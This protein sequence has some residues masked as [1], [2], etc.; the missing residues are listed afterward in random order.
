MKMTRMV[1]ELTLQLVLHPT[2]TARL[3]LLIQPLQK[4]Q[5]LLQKLPKL[6]LCAMHCIKNT[7]MQKAD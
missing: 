1:R 7:A 5:W 3:L 4:Q 2:T 6:D